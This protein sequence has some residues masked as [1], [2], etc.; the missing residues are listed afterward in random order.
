MVGTLAASVVAATLLLSGLGKLLA[1][2]AA[3]S[4]LARVVRVS[5]RLAAVLVSLVALAECSPTPLLIA[6]FARAALIVA[7]IL[8]AGF[9]AFN[10]LERLT[11]HAVARD[12][13]CFGAVADVGGMASWLAL[14]LLGGS[15]AALVFGNDLRSDAARAASSIAAV[16]ISAAIAASIVYRRRAG[17]RPVIDIG[18][19][20]AGA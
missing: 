4:E 16:V 14:A 8:T 15:V 9:V 2:A 17:L 1:P 20:G 13:G 18:L 11:K 6:G 3:A 10:A 5:P 7:L 19:K 12:C